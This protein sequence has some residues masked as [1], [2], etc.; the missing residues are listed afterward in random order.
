MTSAQ[1]DGISSPSMSFVALATCKNIPEPDLDEPLLVGALERAGV[2]T[3]V[4]AWDDEAVDWTAPRLVVIRSTWNYYLHPHT[5]LTWANRQDDRL[6][7]ASDRADWPDERL[8]N[9]S[10]VVEWNHHKRY[11]RELAASGLPVV[12]TLWLRKGSTEDFKALFAERGWND[13]VVKPA[14]SAGSHRTS[15]LI[16]PSFDIDAISELVATGDA[17]AQPY[18]SS[19]ETYGERSLVWIDGE[20]TH[21]IRKSPRFAGGNESVSEVMTIADDERRLAT[22]VLAR[23][24]I[25][26]APLYARVDMVR[27]AG[28][29][30]ML[31]EVE[32]IEPSL[33]LKQS[34]AAKDR[35]VSAIARRFRARGAS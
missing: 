16:G 30:P 5:F 17:M 20:I 27:D 1:A 18:V 6:T 29:A 13:V 24:T 25:L 35:L 14:V 2:P 9:P 32:L 4:L 34:P 21:A 28:G 7:N 3:R 12:P 26:G 19:V 10:N 8:L 23:K 11:L 15:R 31:S 22:E 33:F